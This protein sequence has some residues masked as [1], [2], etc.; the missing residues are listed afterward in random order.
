MSL[1]F[2]LLT[3]SVILVLHQAGLFLLIQG[4]IPPRAALVVAALMFLAYPVLRVLRFAGLSLRPSLRLYGA[5]PGATILATL[6]TVTALPA[7]L[8]ITAR[9]ADPDGPVQQF[10]D[11]LLRTDSPAETAQV[12]FVVVLIPAITEELVFR[13]FL[14]R[15]VEIR[16][17]RW[18]G[19]LISAIPFGVIHGFERAPTAVT[20]GIL[21]GWTASRTGSLLPPIVVH[22]AVNAL[23]IV[24]A[25]SQSVDAG[26]ATVPWSVAATSVLVSVPF[27]AAFR[28][29][30]RGSDPIRGLATPPWIPPEEPPAD[31][32]ER[33]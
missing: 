9:G 4:G 2:V 8:A 18:P 1:R 33:E 27:W 7:I 24:A 26:S 31:P 23:S 14:Q 11:T 30:T 17:G 20:L 28:S 6:G 16:L 22:A 32:P 12:I 15:A 19:I 3:S 29:A 13:G 21:L 10:F 25:N 5:S